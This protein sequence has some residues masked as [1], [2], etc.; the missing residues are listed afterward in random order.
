MKL[1]E[2]RNG[3]TGII[4]KVRGRG[5][6]RRR[7]IEMGFV[8]G[9]EINLVKYAPLN[10]PIEF[11]I[12]NYEVSL[13]KSEAE[14]IEI[15]LKDDLERIENQGFKIMETVNPDPS[16]E[17]INEKIKEINVVIVGNPN[18]GKTTLF[19]YVSGLQERVGNY[20]GVTVTS[21]TASFKHKGYK[22]ILTDLPGT[23]SLSAYSP[24]ELYVRR[25]ILEEI[26]DIV[27]NV[28][29]ASNLERNLY[30][31][32]QLIDM[33]VKVI[34]ALNMYDELI[35]KGDRFN[36]IELGMKLGI[37]FTATVSSKGK[38]INRLFDKVIDFYEDQL[39][40]IRHIHLHYGDETEK[41]ISCIQ[42]QLKPNFLLT[43]KISSR[44]L[45]LKLLEKDKD[46][47]KIIQECENSEKII[48]TTAKQIKH[49]ESSF[50]DDIEVILADARYGFIVGAV[51]EHYREGN[52]NR[53]KVSQNIDSVLTHKFF[54]YP[55]F[56]LFLILM[57]QSTFSLGAYPQALIER[58][59][60]Y[61]H[62]FFNN[63]M[64]DGMLKD[65]ITDGI[66][67]GVG[68]VVVFLPNIL[69]LFF[70]ISIMEDTGYMARVAF[71]MDKLMHKIGMHGKS[72]IPMLM[73]FGCNVPA[74]MATRTIESKNDRLLTMLINPF[75]SCSARLPV[76]I[77]I[78]GAFFPK[79]P[80][81][82]LFAIYFVGILIAIL[83]AI[84][85]KKTILK[86]SEVP[87]V[88]ELPPYRI[89]MLKSSLKHMWNK[90]K[91][92]L[93]KMGGVILVASILIWSLGYFPRNS[94]L[95][96]KFD[97]QSQKFKTE[98][99]SL[100]SQ[101][102]ISVEEK[103]KIKQIENKIDSIVLLKEAVRL[104]YSYIGKIGHFIS[105]VMEP[106]GLNWKMG[107]A[108]FSGVAAKE[109]VVSTLAVLHQVQYS[110]KSET[111]Q[112]KLH[113][114][115]YTQG[116][117][118]GQPVYSPLVAFTFLLFILL[119]FPCIATIVAIKN[120]SGSWKWALF[121]MLYTTGVAW[122]ISFIFYQSGKL[123]GF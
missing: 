70:F 47:E 101:K 82:Y 39:P 91:Q 76:Y 10:D 96:S 109:V 99:S 55:V 6:F 14:R 119:Y 123:L 93:S 41:A 65:L 73:G 34:I 37:P 56:I 19:N 44:F 9:K 81:I 29:D 30:L 53:R 5:A 121:S 83:S 57:F 23:Y 58:M 111:I 95:T 25:Y 35:A 117:F 118:I 42:E 1:S 88:M 50:N 64:N 18:S 52:H 2:L 103:F 122:L 71:I 108:I 7:I 67:N 75:M 97:L 113:N 51:K 49:L 12:L 110:E 105:P 26:P 20:S 107:V 87:F 114:E 45:A 72:F 32:T 13:R 17:E 24:E 8:K 28:V 102:Y 116:K 48:Q 16:I 69:V 68:G 33:D 43:D 84:L 120:E 77:L 100:K 92:Y 3:Q 78:V 98:A 79:N 80:S 106:L 21:K 59:V 11:N 54:G 15:I 40:N 38:G 36:Y 89:P 85:F 104:Q 22:I 115:I 62:E 61:I 66:I 94:S 46:A 74:I 60:S 31:S 90:G 63:I 27:I 4:I 112:Q 86:T